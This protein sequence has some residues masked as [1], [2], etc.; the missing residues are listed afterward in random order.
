MYAANREALVLRHAKNQHVRHIFFFI[1]TCL[2]YMYF[3]V[4][5]SFFFIKLLSLNGNWLKARSFHT[6]SAFNWFNWSEFHYIRIPVE[7]L[8]IYFFFNLNSQVG[9]YKANE[10][11]IRYT[12]CTKCIFSLFIYTDKVARL[13]QNTYNLQWTKKENIHLF[14]APKST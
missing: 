9:F 11:K 4:F 8:F 14:G 3:P 13:L 1:S 10:L 12:K 6:F 7:V 2:P 5:W